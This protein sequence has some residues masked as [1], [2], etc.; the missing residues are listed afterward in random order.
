MFIGRHDVYLCVE[1]FVGVYLKTGKIMFT[2]FWGLVFDT[3]LYPLRK[4]LFTVLAL[5]KQITDRSDIGDNNC[6]SA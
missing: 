6:H 4:M 1:T 5:Y 2:Q 3:E